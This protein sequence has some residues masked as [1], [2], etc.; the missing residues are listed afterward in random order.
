MARILI[1]DDDQSLLELE[2][3][4]LL[5]AGFEVLVAENALIALNL[6]ELYAVDLLIVD[7]QMPRFNGFQ[8]VNT[9]RRNHQFKFIPVAFLS[10]SVE[11]IN[12]IQAA[13]LGADFYI[14]K[15]IDRDALVQ[16]IKSIFDKCPPKQHPKIEFQN[17][18]GI[19]AKVSQFVRIIAITELGVEVQV[20]QKLE[21]G[22]LVE[23]PNL[24]FNEIFAENPRFEVF[25]TTSSKDGLNT[26]FLAFKD[27]S[28]ET[29]RKIQKFILGASHFSGMRSIK[30]QT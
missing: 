15:P 5:N 6:L 2:K 18:V 10:A 4:I 28:H 17:S 23:L 9:V 16:K 3:L 13:K 30:A 24:F 29:I 8:F 26:A 22:Q 19:E 25:S 11:K 1:I 27:R 21:R 20:S 7:I 14:T 12:I